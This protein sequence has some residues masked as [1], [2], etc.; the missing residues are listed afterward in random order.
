MKQL[1]DEI[2]SFLNET[3]QEKKSEKS[4]SSWK[5]FFE[6]FSALFGSYDEKPKV[7]EKEKEKT[8][9]DKPVESD[10]WFEKEYA[11]KA[12]ATTAVE[13][14]LSIFDIYKKSHGMASFT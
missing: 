4:K 12:A 2:D 5:D 3:P 8:K 10:N 1:Q 11:R 7:S 14:T 6:P 9:S 13:S